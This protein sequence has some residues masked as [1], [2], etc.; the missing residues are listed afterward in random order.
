MKITIDGDTKMA[1]T[2]EPLG[3]NGLKYGT[4]Y[5]KSNDIFESWRGYS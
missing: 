3:L 1:I 4:N 2:R 5:N